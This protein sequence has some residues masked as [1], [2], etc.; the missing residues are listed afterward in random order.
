YPSLFRSWCALLGGFGVGGA[1]GV[2]FGSWLASTRDTVIST[3]ETITASIVGAGFG[4]AVFA[5]LAIIFWKLAGSSGAG[6]RSNGS[7]RGKTMDKGR[8]IAALVAFAVLGTVPALIPT[9]YGAADSVVETASS[10]LMSVV[11]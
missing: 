3:T 10:A 5:V 6:L 9:V 2:W 4:L 7:G 11:S 1:S 8:Q